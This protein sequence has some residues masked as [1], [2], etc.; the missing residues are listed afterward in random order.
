M[1]VLRVG[2]W[3]GYPQIL[4]AVFEALRIGFCLRCEE[5]EEDPLSGGEEVEEDP[6]SGSEELD[7]LPLSCKRDDE[8]RRIGERIG[9]AEESR[10]FDRGGV[11]ES[12]CTLLLEGEARCVGVGSTTEVGVG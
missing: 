7:E 11:K 12:S 2:F 5:L 1:A 6:F 10:R 4:A 8:P 9:A 3:V